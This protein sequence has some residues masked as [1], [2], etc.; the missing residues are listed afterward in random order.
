MALERVQKILAQSGIA[1]R[2]KAEE[3]ITEG[4]VTINGKVAQ[5]GDKAD[6]STD[7]IKVSGKL[8]QGKEPETYLAF[9]KPKGVISMLADPEGRPT[10]ADY[11]K[12]VDTRVFPVG[13]LDF[14]SEGLILLTNDGAFAEKL[15]RRDDV[16]RV[17]HV[18]VK[19]HPDNEMLERLRR[20]ARF[21]NRLV[22]PQ[23]VRLSDEFS[24]KARIEIVIMGSGAV[25]LRAFVE[26]RGFLVERITRAAIGHLTING[27]IP[28]SIR[29]LEKSQVEALLNQPELGTRLIEKLQGKKPKYK[30][31]SEEDRE[32]AKARSRGETPRLRKIREKQDEYRTKIGARPKNRPVED[33]SEGSERPARRGFGAKRDGERPARS[34]FGAKRDG[35]RPA[36]SG[37]GAKRD[38]ER[39]ARSGFG[40][41]RDG[42]RPARSG[43]GAKRDGE[44][45]ARSGFGAKR[46]GE[47]P[48]RS[49]F[50]SDRGPKRAERG[51]GVF[52]DREESGE[53][54]PT[55]VKFGRSTRDGE[56]RGFGGGERSE[57]PASG[58]SG[59]GGRSERSEGR[60]SFGGRS[61]RG[62]RESAR[63]AGRGG[64]GSRGGRPGDSAGRPS[65][66]GPGGFSRRGPRRED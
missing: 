45:P 14:M 54:R 37:F 65:R 9:Y 43:F 36:R 20:G 64:F 32:K 5:L 53:G 31:T 39:P 28:G 22:Q 49:G 34:G 46:D 8:L 30:A 55:R 23:S 51:Y 27:L 57:R 10:I 3:L 35:E 52:R 48:A 47:R 4:A 40:A 63:P 17:Y 11:L 15:Q 16:P 26:S 33:E 29:V 12:R 41:K 50:A 66:G 2:R 62:G 60:S 58:R 1:S 24:N 38:G 42:E 25:D 6:L 44:R 13:R 59:F 18:K 61:D 56:S 7:A 21:G 19:G